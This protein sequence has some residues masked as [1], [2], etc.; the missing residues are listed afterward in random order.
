MTELNMTVALAWVA[1]NPNNSAVI[2]GVSSKEQLPQSCRN[3]TPEMLEIEGILVNKP[4]DHVSA[5]SRVS[6]CFVLYI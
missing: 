3:L 1:R 4:A 2:L 5:G 6:F